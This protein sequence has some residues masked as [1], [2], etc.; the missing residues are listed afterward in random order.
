LIVQIAHVQGRVTALQISECRRHLVVGQDEVIAT[1]C[2][3][4]PLCL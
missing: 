3:S 2:L 4:I 1:L